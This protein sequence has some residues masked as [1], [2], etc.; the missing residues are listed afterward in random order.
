MLSSRAV[1]AFLLCLAL[2]GASLVEPG[3]AQQGSTTPQPGQAEAPA[4]QAPPQT[5]EAQPQTPV[6]RTGIN[7]VRVDVIVGDRK[8]QPVTDLSQKDFELFEDGK[9]REI[10][11]FS[12]VRTDGNPRPGAP[13]PRA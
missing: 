11:Q 3:S 1:P 13:P 8:D 5:G 12:L 4:S 6:F 9:P 10:E 2:V 7:F